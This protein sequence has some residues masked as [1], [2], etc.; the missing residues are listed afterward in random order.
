MG[1]LV[2]Y[3]EMRIAVEQCARIDEAADLRD[4][5]SA[6]AAYAKQRDDADLEVWMGEIKVRA[7]VRIGELVRDLEK[8]KPG[9]VPVEDTSQRREVISK[10]NAIEAA[11]LSR[12]EAYRLQDLAG[13]KDENL[14]KAGKAAA[15]VYF[16][17]ARV[18]KVPATESGL[19]AAVKDAVHSAMGDDEIK[20]AAKA[21]KP[22]DIAKKRD[23][24][25]AR[26]RDLAEKTRSA[27]EQI[28]TQLYGVVYADPPWRF[29]PYSRETGMDRAA[30]NHYPTEGTD[31]ICEMVPPS[32]DSAVLF[33]WAT[34]PMLPDGI[35]VMEAWGFTYKRHVVWVKDRIGT[36]Y[37]AR[38]KHELMLIGTRGSVPAPSPGTQFCSVVDAPLGRHS[39]KPVVFAEM[40]ETMFPNLAK[41]EMF[42][43]SPRPGWDVWGNQ[44]EQAA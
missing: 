40:I 38:N 12:P 5:A 25:D 6:L 39:E 18:S 2:K 43:R 16:A 8:A 41:L 13:P 1:T 11:G 9:P 33:L 26:E 28:G 23:A 14:Q 30:D 34:A 36:G 15:E 19:K 21:L 24:R 44:A 20:R 4:K 7:S 37:W 32:A 29:E 10:A 22:A 27:A 31:A 35:R 17:Q 42:C 3:E